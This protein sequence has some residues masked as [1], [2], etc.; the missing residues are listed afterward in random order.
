METL[1]LA[2]IQVSQ[3]IPDATQTSSSWDL[4][5]PGIRMEAY[6]VIDDR[7]K[8]ASRIDFCIDIFILQILI[9][10]RD[11]NHRLHISLPPVL[12]QHVVETLIVVLGLVVHD[13]SV[14]ES[15]QLLLPI[16]NDAACL[17][18][19]LLLLSIR[20]LML[21]LHVLCVQLLSTLHSLH[22][23]LVFHLRFLV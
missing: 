22:L 23:S 2:R 19:L 5:T 7:L 6:S 13:A 11:C 16:H 17:P 8:S 18:P 12:V 20:L 21:H 15:R 3:V 9:V 4:H 1:P 10:L 14:D